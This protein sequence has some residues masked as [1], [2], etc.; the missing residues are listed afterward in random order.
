MTHAHLPPQ[1]AADARVTSALRERDAWWTVLVVDPIALPL[2]AVAR[3]VP[4][5]TP[6][7][8]TVTALL[9]GAASVLSF[10][11]GQLL[12]AALLFEV[13]FV[14]DCVDGKLA[15]LTSASSRW[16][17]FADLASDTLVVGSAYAALGYAMMH[18]AVAGAALAF[19]LLPA[20]TVATWLHLYRRL[21]LGETERIARPAVAPR[22]AWTWRRLR[23]YPGAVEAETLI[24][25]A[26]PLLMPIEWFPAV[27]GIGIGFYTVSGLDSLRRI[28]RA[29]R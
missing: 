8:V 11:T 1:P 9:V 3:R 24:L 29:H 27:C 18:Q 23:P 10:A 21:A 17:A 7:G 19:V 13:R 2:L 15:R 25:F 20:F 6:M 28:R 22:R 26:F 16:G 12:L 4:G 5:V 14:L